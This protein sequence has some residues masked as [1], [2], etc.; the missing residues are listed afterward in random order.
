MLPIP[1]DLGSSMR[2]LLPMMVG[3]LVFAASPRVGRAAG[4]TASVV[5]GTEEDSAPSLPGLAG[6][7]GPGSLDASGL[8]PS[9]GF[10]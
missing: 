7:G 5:P 10:S 6:P 2:R 8:I 1:F 4:N 3:L 9:L